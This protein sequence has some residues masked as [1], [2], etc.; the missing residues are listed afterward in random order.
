MHAYSLYY[1]EIVNN[2][3]SFRLKFANELKMVPRFWLFRGNA[4]LL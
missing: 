3:Y 4:V 1:D 2:I